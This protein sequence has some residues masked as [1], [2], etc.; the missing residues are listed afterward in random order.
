MSSNSGSLIVCFL[1]FAGSISLLTLRPSPNECERRR[2]SDAEDPALIEAGFH[3]LRPRIGAVF[4][5]NTV[6]EAGGS[7]IAVET[8]RQSVPPARQAPGNDGNGEGE[9]APLREHAPALAQRGQRVVD[10]FEGVGV[11]DHV[12]RFVFERKMEDVRFRIF[13]QPMAGAPLDEVREVSG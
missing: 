5:M 9:D 3:D 10:V 8:R 4:G 6:I 11:T 7:G 1:Y 2:R 12:E 13:H